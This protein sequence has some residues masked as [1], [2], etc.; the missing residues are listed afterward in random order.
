MIELPLQS[1]L[2]QVLMF[3]ETRSGCHSRHTSQEENEGCV[4]F[5]V[6]TWGDKS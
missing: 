5:G 4:F 2:K 3:G 1:Q 6:L